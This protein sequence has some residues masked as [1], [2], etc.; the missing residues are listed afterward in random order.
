MEAYTEPICVF[1]SVAF[2][3]TCVCVFF[4][5]KETTFSALHEEVQQNPTFLPLGLETILYNAFALEGTHAS[6]VLGS[7]HGQHL[8]NGGKKKRAVA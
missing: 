8:S 2:T 4:H 5:P 6:C 3:C 7:F 1:A